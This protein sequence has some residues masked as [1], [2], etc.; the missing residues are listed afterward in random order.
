MIGRLLKTLPVL[1]LVFALACGAA[2]T[3]TPS[4]TNAP[5][6]TAIQPGIAT[7][8]PAPAVKPA[9]VVNPGKLTVMVG[10]LGNERFDFAFT[11]DS[12]KGN[13]YG[14]TVH[15]FLISDN[16]TREMV[17]GIASQWGLSADGLTW[18]FT[19]RKGVKF[20]DGTEL[21]TEDALWSLQ[22]SWGPQ[23][24]EYAIDSTALVA[25]RRMNRIEMSGSDKVSM[26]TKAPVTEIAYVL[27]EAGI[28][29]HGIMPKRAKLH[30]T[31][32]EEAYDKKPI[33]AG[34]MRLVKHVPNYSMTFERFDDFYYQPKN[35]FPED[36]RMKFQLLDVFLAP[37]EATRVAAVR[38]GEADIVP[39][40]L[41]T[42]NQIETAGRRLV[43][44]QEGI[45]VY[46]KLVGCWEPQHPCHD[47][48]V[49][50]ALDYAI[51]KDLIRDRLYGGSE[52]FQVKG[53]TAVTPS[54][55]GYTR[56]LDPL[57]FDPNKARQLLADAG[58]PGGQGFGKLIVNTH[59]S[60][61]IPFMVEGAQL[62]A[63]F[64][65]RE[66]GLDTEVRVGDGVG[67]RKRQQAGELN[68]QL[69]WYDV[70]GRK[71]ATSTMAVNYGDLESPN[72]AH[73]D[74][75]LV[76]LV[77]ETFGILNVDE[78]AEASKKLYLRLRDESYNLGIG[79][80]N[81]PWGVGPRVLTWSPYS[82]SNHPSA[83]HTIT[84]K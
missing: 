36:K 68:G 74:P 84:L 75:E 42:K 76:R 39:V 54:T 53:W 55:I 43:F 7:A 49:R 60:I 44:G 48:R 15:G 22:H 37:E 81:I 21:T 80:V 34:P 50:Q 1:T 16:E 66:L 6:S 57:P 52:V 82:L 51:N 13:I 72:R 83:L 38:A 79:Y 33:G 64:W 71:D 19:I 58:Y 11:V 40:S 4:P 27:S 32:E 67:I 59:P 63:E 30:D 23:A 35:G 20:H 28:F 8:T 10:S 17:P 47:K 18:T 62:G 25:S 65:R 41:A 77:R 78:Q 61:S 56:E 14:R 12:T 9:A 3:A 26:V 70:T 31:A 73:G 29:S 5:Q 46:I 45:S 2:A 24:V 69:W